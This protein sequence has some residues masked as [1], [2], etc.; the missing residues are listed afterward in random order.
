MPGDNVDAG[1]C[2]PR[3]AGLTDRLLLD[4]FILN[5]YVQRS[6]PK[7]LRFYQLCDHQL[8]LSL[9]NTRSSH[10]TTFR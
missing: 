2:S 4:C 5:L 10:Y 6:Y 7:G 8:Y 9:Y 1:L 3:F